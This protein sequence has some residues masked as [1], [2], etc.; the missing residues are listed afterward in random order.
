MSTV[1]M[2]ARELIAEARALYAA[3][4]E[5]WAS[6]PDTIS[7][8]KLIVLANYGDLALGYLRAIASATS[9]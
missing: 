8:A 4:E 9:N 3:Y 6:Q 1:E 5:A 7:N 2:T